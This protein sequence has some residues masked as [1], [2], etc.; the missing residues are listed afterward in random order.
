MSVLSSSSRERWWD[1]RASI[2]GSSVRL[3]CHAR[4]F[5]SF[6]NSLLTLVL[7]RIGPTYTEYPQIQSIYIRLLPFAGATLQP[8][9][10][11]AHEP[12]GTF[13]CKDQSSLTRVC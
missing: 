12:C 13:F 10:G 8:Q 11:S 9:K 6:P 3:S 7:G 1:S 2:S 5:I 4:K